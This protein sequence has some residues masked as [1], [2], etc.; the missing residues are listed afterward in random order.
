MIQDFLMFQ[1]SLNKSAHSI[2]ILDRVRH[3]QCIFEVDKDFDLP[4]AFLT[5]FLKIWMFSNSWYQ[6]FTFRSKSEQ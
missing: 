4:R 1:I 3:F 6:S 5:H 2:L